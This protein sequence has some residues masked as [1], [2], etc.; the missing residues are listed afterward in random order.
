[1][2]PV[3]AAMMSTTSSRGRPGLPCAPRIG[4]FPFREDLKSLFGVAT[5]SSLSVQRPAAGDRR[6]AQRND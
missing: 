2:P 5:F 4:D 3:S 1:M 6:A